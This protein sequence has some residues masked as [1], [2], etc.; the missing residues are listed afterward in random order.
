MKE[1][2]AVNYIKELVVILGFSLLG[3]VIKMAV[4]L[5][6]PAGIYGL[7][8]LFLALVLGVVKLGQVAHTGHYIIE[9]MI[10]MFIAP[11]VG[12]LKTWSILSEVL[13]P[14]CVIVL[15]TTIAVMVVTGHVAQWLIRR[16]EQK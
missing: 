9:I 3:E 10:V 12:L 5:P 15:L 6:V 11:S 8:L 4:P 1:E 16:R 13:V 14:Y 7:L 2:I